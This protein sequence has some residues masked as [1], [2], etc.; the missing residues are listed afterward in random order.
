M[1]LITILIISLLTAGVIGSIVPMMPGALF[2]LAG[3][4][5]YFFGS[6]DPSIWFTLFGLLTAGL[7]LIFDWFAGS[8]AAKYGGASTKTSFAAGV[9]G[10]IGFVVTFGNPVGLFAAV[11]FTVFIRE[12]LIH[13]DRDRSVKAV[14]YATVGVLG[15]SVIQ[16]FL[17]ASILIGFVLT[18]LI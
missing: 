16:A 15:S 8:V 13:E 3:I 2:S 6:S 4:L 5:A 17:T 11:A 18:L 9:A 7:A 10:L 1:E 12:Y 14:L